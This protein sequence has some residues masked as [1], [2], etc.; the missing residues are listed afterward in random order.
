MW[1]KWVEYARRFSR[2]D[3]LEIAGF[4][5]IGGALAW[6]HPI[7]GLLWLGILLVATSAMRR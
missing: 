4:A 5:C 2:V 7:V 3:W 6:W 1:K